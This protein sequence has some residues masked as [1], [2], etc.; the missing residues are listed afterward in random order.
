M[1]GS[2]Y[3]P[4]PT[5]AHAFCASSSSSSSGA[6][7]SGS[8]SRA[9]RSIMSASGPSSAPDTS[10]CSTPTGVLASPA[11]GRANRYAKPVAAAAA[12]VGLQPR[13]LYQQQQQQG[14]SSSSSGGGSSSAT[15][16]T[17]SASVA[18]DDA[19]ALLNRQAA[20][21]GVPHA[22]MS[23]VTEVD[24]WCSVHSQADPDFA[25]ECLTP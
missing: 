2:N 15:S 5:V 25:S 11:G 8:D 7:A 20:A 4:D 17:A 1:V 14:S 22:I 12:M 6:A 16:S 23:A 9:G 24:G 21:V 10:R 3:R 19:A 18:A 13:T